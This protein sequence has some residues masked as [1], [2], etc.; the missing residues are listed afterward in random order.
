MVGGNPG[1]G[2][3]VHVALM[4]RQR[5]ASSALRP[6]AKAGL[7]RQWQEAAFAAAASGIMQWYTTPSTTSM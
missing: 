7:K 3:G 2:L 6:K 5:S 1:N 4:Q